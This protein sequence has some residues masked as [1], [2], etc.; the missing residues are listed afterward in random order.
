MTNYADE[1]SQQAQQTAGAGKT[2]SKPADPIRVEQDQ[3]NDSSYV[4]WLERNPMKYTN[5]QRTALIRLLQALVS[6]GINI[7]GLIH[8]DLFIV[9]I[10]VIGLLL[11]LW[12][13]E[14][15]RRLRAAEVIHEAA[16][17]LL[18]RAKR[19]VCMY[20]DNPLQTATE[21]VSGLCATGHHT[22]V[23]QT[24]E[25]LDKAAGKGIH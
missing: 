17:E 2:Q 8:Q 11:V 25:L 23:K 3:L 22:E 18:A 6:A 12:A 19:G 10:G 15:D 9:A 4:C 5:W 20:C 16:S 13:S 24:S 1:P 21:R 7:I 14:I